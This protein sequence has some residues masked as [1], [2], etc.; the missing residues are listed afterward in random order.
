MK[1][2]FKLI[3]F[4]AVLFTYSCNL[5]QDTQATRIEAVFNVDSSLLKDELFF[6]SALNISLKIPRNWSKMNAEFEKLVNSNLLIN[7]YKKAQL[8]LGYLN[9]KDSSIMVL[10][11]VTNIDGSAY[12]DLKNN[13]RE[14]L[15][16]DQM[17]SD[18]QFQ[19]FDYNSFRIEQYVLQN[20]HILSFK[21]VCY[22][23]EALDSL[24]PKVEVQYIINRKNLNDN[25][26]SV[27]S[28]IGT[29]NQINKI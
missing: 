8:R 15:N 26:K 2:K 9:E 29:I 17:W 4:F 3:I 6:D 5:Q 18:I 13:Y 16:R 10:L 22:E 20:E 28:S 14:I 12:A 11:D 19:E 27:E 21:L 24:L 25:I 1:N 23:N 7:D